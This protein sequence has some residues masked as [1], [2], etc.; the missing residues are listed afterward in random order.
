MAFRQGYATRATPMAE[1]QRMMHNIHTYLKSVEDIEKDKIKN[2]PP[3]IINKDYDNGSSTL[4]LPHIDEQTLIGNING[5]YISAETSN[6]P[7]C[8]EGDVSS[9]VSRGVDSV[10]LQPVI[11]GHFDN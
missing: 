3:F 6:K 8:E 10:Q 11:H 4:Q 2:L 5:C 9:P 7:S 1:I